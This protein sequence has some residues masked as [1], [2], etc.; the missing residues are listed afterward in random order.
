MLFQLLTVGGMLIIFLSTA[1]G[2]SVVFFFKGEIS[3]KINALFLGFASGVMVAT[4]VWSLIL[5]ALET[6]TGASLQFSCMLV[7]LALVV[8]GLFLS[9]L[10][11]L[12]KRLETKGNSAKIKA[13]RLFFAVTLHNIPE[14]LAVGFAFGTAFIHGTFGGYI[15][16][17]AL[18]V[19]IAFQNLPEGMAVALPMKTAMHSNKKAFLFGVGS[20]V[21]E[22]IFALFGYFT[23]TLLRGVQPYLLAFSAGAML[24]VTADDLLPDSKIK[25][26]KSIGAWGFMLG[27]SVMMLLDILLG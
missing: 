9:G 15:T 23:A 4:S 19:G 18:A 5:P 8:G 21:V 10:G 24:F 6:F 17:F 12:T 14:G 13:K 2:A 3:T 22:P 25:D 26:E 11:Y 20:G 1:L 27:F 7:A 16:A